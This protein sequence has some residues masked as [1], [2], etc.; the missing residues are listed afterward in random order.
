MYLQINHSSGEHVYKQD[1]YLV[2]IVFAHD[3]EPNSTRSSAAK[4]TTKR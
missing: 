1:P 4:G 2:L 3:L